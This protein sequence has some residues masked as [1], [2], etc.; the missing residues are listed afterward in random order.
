MNVRNCRK[1]GRIYNYVAGPP[2][3]PACQEELERK[4]REV[5]DYIR[6]NKGV[7]I[8]QVAEECEVEVSQIRQWLR[9][10][11]LELVENSGIVLTCDN[12]GAP[13]TSGRYCQKCKNE[14]AQGL[15]QAIGGNK[16]EPPKPEKDPR[17][18]SKMRFL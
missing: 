16:K 18:K 8:H 3:C 7:G 11:R 4:F 13:V 14:L 2:I 12:C 9:E 17:E 15:T 5:R 10:E 6:D 1:C